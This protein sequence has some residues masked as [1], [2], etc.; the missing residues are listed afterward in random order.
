MSREVGTHHALTNP[1]QAPGAEI[2]AVNEFLR[3][4]EALL[5]ASAKLSRLLLEAPEPMRVMPAALRLLGEAAEV[6]RTTLALAETDSQG[7]RWLNIKEKWIAE[8]LTA[9]E[10]DTPSPSWSERKSDCFCPELKAGRTV[11][12]RRED[13]DDVG[14]I[15]IAGDRARSAV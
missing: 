15:S 9:V 6:D 1:A 8:G 14:G 7:E 10:S 13:P 4:R 2:L 12:V 3:R 5:A 11:F